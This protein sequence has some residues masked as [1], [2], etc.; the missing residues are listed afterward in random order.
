MQRY[1]DAIEFLTRGIN[2]FGRFKRWTTAAD[3]VSKQ[4]DRMVAL[5]S[6]AHALSPSVRLDD[7]I[8]QGVQDKYGDQH[9][10]MLRGG[11]QAEEVFSE[12][13]MWSCPKF[14]AANPPPYG[15]EEAMAQISKGNEKTKTMLDPTWHHHKI[16]LASIRP[17]LAAPDFR[18]FLKL[19]TTL[20]ANKLAGLMKRDKETMWEELAVMKGGMRGAQWK[21]GMSLVDGEEV[22]SENADICVGVDGETIEITEAKKSRATADYF[23]RHGKL[24]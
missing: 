6:M 16:F 19:H 23:I 18:S 21:G 9:S 3:Q 1:A 5:V 10:R 17:M 15:D 24:L 2:H 8:K 7:W 4:V 11:Q 14:V 13:F 22:G 20:D 12:L